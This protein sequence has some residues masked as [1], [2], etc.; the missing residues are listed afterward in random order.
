MHAEGEEKVPQLED[1]VEWGRAC[2]KGHYSWA[3]RAMCEGERGERERRIGGR[4]WESVDLCGETLRAKVVEELGI[5]DL[6]TSVQE[7]P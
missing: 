5:D 2:A 6:E 4:T 3:G 1:L 7:L